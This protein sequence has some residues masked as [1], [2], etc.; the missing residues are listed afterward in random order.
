MLYE[1]AA[2]FLA[3]CRECFGAAPELRATA[4]GWTDKDGR[5]VLEI[6]DV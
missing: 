4:N 3:M 5:L 6:V 2:E 1:S